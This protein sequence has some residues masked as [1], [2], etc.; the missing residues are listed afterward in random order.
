MQLG[1]VSGYSWT[2]AN[3]EMDRHG[4]VLKKG[5]GYARL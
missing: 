1:I 3:F 2:I 4:R 5:S